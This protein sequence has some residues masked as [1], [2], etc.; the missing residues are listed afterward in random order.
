VPR[1]HSHSTAGVDHVEPRI[2]RPAEQF[3]GAL[4][5][6]VP[7][8]DIPEAERTGH[9]IRSRQPAAMTQQRRYLGAISRSNRASLDDLAVGSCAPVRSE[10]RA[11]TGV[12][13]VHLLAGPRLSRQ[14][15]HRIAEPQELPA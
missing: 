2:D 11:Q 14:T 6:D 8:G 3:H 4:D 1:H 15:D 10:G 13:I 7:V 12:G 5:R 9:E